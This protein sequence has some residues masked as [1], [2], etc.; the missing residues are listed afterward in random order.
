MNAPAKIEVAL[1][2][3]SYPIFIEPGLFEHSGSLL[4][5]FARGPLPVVT[6]ENVWAA[7]GERFLVGLSAA[8]IE[9]T[10]IVLPPGESTKSWS[11]LAA[12]TDR[13]L[14]LGVERSGHIVAFGGGVIG[15]LAG[16]AAAIVKR[17]CGYDPSWRP[18]CSRRST[19]RSAARP[20]S[21]SPLAR[22]WS[23]P[24]TSRAWC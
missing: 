16:F 7:Q 20:R 3:R 11:H 9:A 19:A 22:I 5:P 24:S 8:G 21:T 6:D 2:E 10:P 1:G 18:P 13:L 17:G 12:L 23:A 14:A 4:A 15:D